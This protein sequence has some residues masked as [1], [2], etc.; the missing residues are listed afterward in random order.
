MKTAPKLADVA[1]SP[2]AAGLIGKS[3]DT[4]RYL[5]KQPGFPSPVTISGV[6]FYSRAE[7]AAWKAKRERAKQ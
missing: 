2:E 7:L 3:L 6:K 1:P 4:F 5:A